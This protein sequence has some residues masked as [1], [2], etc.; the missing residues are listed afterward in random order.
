MNRNNAQLFITVPLI[1][2]L[3]YRLDNL[4]VYSSL[5]QSVS[6]DI[7][8]NSELFID[9]NCEKP[10]KSKSDAVPDTS[11]TLNQSLDVINSS[12]VDLGDLNGDGY[13]D[14]FISMFDEQGNRVFLN[15]KTGK[16]TDSGQRLGNFKSC[17]VELGDLNGDGYLDAFVANVHTP[18]DK[19][20][21]PNTV[22][23]NDGTGNFSDSGQRLGNF[24][25]SDVKLID[26][27]KDGDLDAVVANLHNYDD[28]SVGQPDEI[29][30]NNGKGV[31]TLKQLIGNHIS[32][33]V[34]AV[35]VNN[36]G[37]I[38][39]CFGTQYGDAPDELWFGSDSGY[40]TKSIKFF[41]RSGKSCFCRFADFNG[42]KIPDMIFSDDSKPFRVLLNDGKAN[43]T[44]ITGNLGNDFSGNFDVG[45]INN[46]GD[47]DV[48]VA[49]GRYNEARTSKIYL[50]NG[51]GVFSESTIEL[52][53][54]KS[55][56]AKL[57]D[58]D[59]D[60][61]LDAY[62]VNRNSNDMIWFNN[63]IISA[64]GNAIKKID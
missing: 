15:D 28:L 52:G 29:W 4:R 1:V 58:F 62:I 12:D 2:L 9:S 36:D 41:V 64:S 38:D 13:M 30:I 24:A 42:D 47:L 49:K 61:D 7:S 44:E 25:S 17:S 35:D 48:I 3:I 6:S 20:G 56:G 54:Y 55:S 27:E 39:L 22:W 18:N 8:E 51:K 59:K 16:L 53:T 5:S 40:L 14:A 33:T 19:N 31:F 21:Q 26:L 11:F 63:L 50:N 45:D 57:A 37:Y 34:D 10:R 23:F 60:G 32:G 46:D 43:F